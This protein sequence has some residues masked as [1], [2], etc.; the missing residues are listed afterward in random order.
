MQKNFVHSLIKMLTFFL[1][2]LMSAV[3]FM[4]VIMRYFMSA[5]LAWSDEMSRYLMVWIT[6]LGS[7]LAFYEGS[8]PAITFAVE[9]LSPRHRNE[10][11][12]AINLALLVCF[13]I[14]GI[15]GVRLAMKTH[16]FL[17]TSLKLPMSMVYG[18]LPV[19]MF[20]MVYKIL[21]DFWHRFAGRSPQ[22]E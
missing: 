12:F 6:F 7:A 1:F 8:H 17:S 19:S 13:T 20:L 14:C 4:Q 21:F 3:V 10:L 5:P 22:S 16:R 18:A 11:A 9:K 15:N 2:F